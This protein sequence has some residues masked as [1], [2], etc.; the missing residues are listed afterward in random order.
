MPV[1]PSSQG[2][3]RLGLRP[4]A[5]GTGPGVGQRSPQPSTPSAA[6]PKATR[7]I[8]SSSPWP[9]GRH[10]MLGPWPR[11]VPGH[12]TQKDGRGLTQTLARFPTSLGSDAAPVGCHPR[13]RSE[14]DRSARPSMEA[15]TRRRH[16]R[17]D[18]TH[19]EPQDQP[20]DLPGSGSSDKPKGK[21]RMQTSKSCSPPLTSEVISTPRFRRGE[22]R[23]RGTS[24]GYRRSLASVALGAAP[25]PRL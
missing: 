16:G 21:I 14:A 18:P 12:R 13:W 9:T 10:A 6:W 25:R 15:G 23:D 20:S 1:V 8:Q 19:G 22:W 3:G 2:P 24:G 7:P 11:R 17:W 5:V 4:R